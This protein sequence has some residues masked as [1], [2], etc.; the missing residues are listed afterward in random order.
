LALQRAWTVSVPDYP[1]LDPG[2]V[3]TVWWNN[4]VSAQVVE[5]VTY[6]LSADQPVYLSTREWRSGAVDPSSLELA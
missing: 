3:I 5:S 2:D 6:P 1:L 4:E